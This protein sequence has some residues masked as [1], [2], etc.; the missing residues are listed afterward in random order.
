MQGLTVRSV[1]MMQAVLLVITS[2][3]VGTLVGLTV[4]ALWG[5][6]AAFGVTQVGALGILWQMG[7]FRSATSKRPD[8]PMAPPMPGAG[9]QD[10]KLLCEDILKGE[11]LNMV[12]RAVA[13]GWPRQTVLVALSSV[14]DDAALASRSEPATEATIHEIL[15]RGQ[16]P[17]RQT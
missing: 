3:L 16:R 12:D 5:I 1:A 11:V 6:I 8:A 13:A 4:G 2:W 10:L 17:G 14:A 9:P 7:R 15:A